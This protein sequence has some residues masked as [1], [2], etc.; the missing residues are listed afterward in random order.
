MSQAPPAVLT[1]SVVGV[2]EEEEEEEF[3]PNLFGA[4]STSM[5]RVCS[6]A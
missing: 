2:E 5:T 6:L 1:A 3:I 4:A